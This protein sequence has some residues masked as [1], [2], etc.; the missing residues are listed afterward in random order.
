MLGLEKKSK[1]SD[2]RIKDL[3]ERVKKLSRENEF[4]KA[5][6]AEQGALTASAAAPATIEAAEN[7]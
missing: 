5:A 6:L 7:A 3:Q 2:K 1:E 4:L